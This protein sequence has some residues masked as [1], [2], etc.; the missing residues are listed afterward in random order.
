MSTDIDRSVEAQ[1]YRHLVHKTTLEMLRSLGEICRLRCQ[2]DPDL[3][4]AIASG[5][6]EFLSDG[7]VFDQVMVSLV[8]QDPVYFG[9][10]LDRLDEDKAKAVIGVVLGHTDTDGPFSI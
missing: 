8:S 6:Y 5:I 2:Q 7:D 3:L 9:G 10:I 4:D 1:D